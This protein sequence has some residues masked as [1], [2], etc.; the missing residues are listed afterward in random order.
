MNKIIGLFVVCVLFL[1]GFGAQ[2]VAGQK[3]IKKKAVALKKVEWYGMWSVPSRFRG[4]NL[5]INLVTAKKFDFKLEASNGANQGEIS[6]RALINGAKAFFDDRNSTEKDAEKTGCRLTFTHKG[7]YIDVEQTD[8]CDSYAGNAVFFTGKYQ[9]DAMVLKENDFVSNDVFPDK[10]TDDKFKALVGKDYERFLD[11]FHLINEE[12]NL[13]AFGAKAVSACVRGICPWNAGII[14]YN[15]AGNFW[16]AVMELE[17]ETDATF[18]NYYTNV[19]D[20]TG[21]LPKTIENWV[22]DKRKMNDN[23]TVRFKKIDN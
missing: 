4:A 8:E 6:G 3:K 2:N 20:W 7:A 12:E 22:T 15:E 1:A 23:L 5:T 11:A 14:M 18:V 10:A 16:A 17:D 21:K 9:K 13:D 19:P